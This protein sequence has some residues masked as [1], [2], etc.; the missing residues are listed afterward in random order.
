M[1][2]H[3]KWLASLAV[4]LSVATAGLWLWHGR[5]SSVASAQVHD[6]APER[7]IEQIEASVEASQVFHDGLA[8]EAKENWK[9]INWNLSIDAALK[10]AQE[11][12][13]PVLVLLSVRE[14]GTH[15]PGRC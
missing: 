14:V 10:M 2:A 12:K 9:K 5:G 15:D 1:G 4:V 11:L 13:K 3:G 8:Q 7:S 6:D